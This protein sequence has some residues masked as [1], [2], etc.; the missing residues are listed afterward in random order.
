M[1]Q[2]NNA[3]AQGL[4]NAATTRV[5]EMFTKWREE[6]LSLK[7][8]RSWTNFADKTQF[9]LPKVTEVHLRLKN[10]LLFY[11]TNYVIVFFVLALYCM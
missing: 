10:N 9:A 3:A 11:Q 7:S 2:L 6:K 1:D 8:M 4:A 5:R